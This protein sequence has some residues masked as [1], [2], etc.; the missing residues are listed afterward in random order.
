[1]RVLNRQYRGFDVP[2][3]VLAF[4][5]QEGEPKGLNS[6]L[7]GDIVISL[8]MAERQADEVGHSLN[9][10]L[11]ILMIHGLLHLIGFDHERGG[12]EEKRMKK[13]E[14]QILSGLEILLPA[15]E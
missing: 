8:E 11:A 6:K 12:P 1:M 15:K 3:D 2:T 13:K 14:G 9:K 5:M 4:P 10:E 7:L